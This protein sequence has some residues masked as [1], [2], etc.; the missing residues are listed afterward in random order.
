MDVPAAR[1]VYADWP[2]PIVASGYEIGRAIKFPAANI[3]SDFNYVEHHPLKEAYCLYKKMPYDRETWDLTSVLYAVRPGHGYFGISEPGT[4]R[5][6]D[7][8]ITRFTPSADGMHRYL[9][10][11]PQQITRVREALVQLASQPPLQ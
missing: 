1:K 6:D 5:V 10:V 2:T 8:H 3:L 11:T 4:I 9:T 7:Q